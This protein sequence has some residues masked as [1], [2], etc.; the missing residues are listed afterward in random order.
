[1]L[2][3]RKRSQT[4]LESCVA[5]SGFTGIGGE[6]ES[7]TACQGNDVRNTYMSTPTHTAMYCS[8]PA[9]MEV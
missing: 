1:M 2:T 3:H 5:H 7:N 4:S 9:C 8:T 6:V